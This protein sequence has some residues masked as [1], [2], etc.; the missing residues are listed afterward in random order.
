MP[1]VV[2]FGRVFGEATTKPDFDTPEK[3]GSLRS[4]RPFISW[5]NPHAELPFGAV[6]RH[7]MALARLHPDDDDDHRRI[8]DWMDGD[9]KSAANAGTRTSQ[10]Q[11]RNRAKPLRQLVEIV[12]SPANSQLDY[13][14]RTRASISKAEKREAVL[15]EGYTEWLLTRGRKL[16]AAKYG[17]LRCDGIETV[18][19]EPE[20]T[21][22]VEAKCSARREYIRM[23]VGQLLDYEFQGREH[24]AN[25]HKAIL[26]PEKP[27]REVLAWLNSIQIKVVWR[28]GNAF[29]DND[30]GRFT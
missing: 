14:V 7:T 16:A 17:A 19:G 30:N 28:S 22:L 13:V 3:F 10:A 23:A 21:N 4:M 2:G 6:V 25:T 29:V 11:S 1:E 20:S 15:L 18:E 24:F 5:S 9:L 12:A 8:C 27:P 26:L